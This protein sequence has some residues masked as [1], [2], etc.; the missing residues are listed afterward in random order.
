M[1]KPKPIICPMCGKPALLDGDKI[2]CEQCDAI[3][4]ITKEGGARVQRTGVF[5]NHEQ[6]IAVLEGAQTA[7]EEPGQTTEQPEDPD[8]DEDEIFPQ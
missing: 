6:R 3:Y 5:D 2:A 8:A 4:K 7:P 1:A